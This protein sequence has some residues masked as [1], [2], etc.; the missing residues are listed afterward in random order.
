MDPLTR[1]A[2]VANGGTIPGRVT[3]AQYPSAYFVTYVLASAMAHPLLALALL[4]ALLGACLHSCARCVS[5]KNKTAGGGD[6]KYQAV[7][8]S[9]S[10]STCPDL[11][12]VVSGTSEVELREAMG[13]AI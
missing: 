2:I 3:F 6:F 13:K 10:T 5:R 12:S 7:S 8:T 4:V 9:T 11:V 1:M